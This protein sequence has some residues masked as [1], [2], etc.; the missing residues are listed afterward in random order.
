[1]NTKTENTADAM[2]PLWKELNSSDDLTL[3]PVEPA[4]EN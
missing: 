2:S 3:C 4:E 1:M